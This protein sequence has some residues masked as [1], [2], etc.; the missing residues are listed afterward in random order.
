MQIVGAL[1][2]AF[3]FLGPAFGSD[4][5]LVV[6]N[7]QTNSPG[8][9]TDNIGAVGGVDFHFQEVVDNTEFPAGGKILI[10][11][12][13][14]RAAPGTGPITLT[15]M[16]ILSLSTT[17]F[18]ANAIG[19]NTMLTNTYATNIGPDNTVV[20]SGPVTFTS[21]GCAGP[22]VC[23]FDMVLKFATP[24]PYDPSQGSLLLDFEH[25]GGFT[26]GGFWDAVKYSPPGGPVAAVSNSGD[27]ATGNVIPFGEVFQLS[28]TPTIPPSTT[29]PT[30]TASVGVLYSSQVAGTGVQRRLYLGSV[31][32]FACSAHFERERTGIRNPHGRR[33]IELHAEHHRQC[34]GER[35][36][37]VHHNGVASGYNLRM[38]GEYSI[39]RRR[40]LVS[41][42]LA[43]GGSGSGIWS[44][45]AGSL[46]PLTLSTGGLISGIPTAA[47]VL[48]F[49]VKIADSSGG[50]AQQPCTLTVT[51]PL[52]TTCPIA[53]ATI[54][55]VYF[56]PLIG[57]GGSGAGYSWSLA[58]GSLAPLTLDPS[59]VVSGSANTAVVLNFTLKI[60][61]SAGSTAQQPCTIVFTSLGP[62]SPKY[63]KT[64]INV[65]YSSQL[66]GFGGS[67]MRR[68]NGRWQVLLAWAAE[69]ERRAGWSLFRWPTATGTLIFNLLITDSAG[70]DEHY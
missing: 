26:G 6:P 24:F 19:G 3:V 16:T 5:L 59:G 66:V 46:A 64:A 7:A 63:S 17:P 38:S 32:R 13:A 52:S 36:T 25:I 20:F 61:D 12:V 70:G 10:T 56:S 57:T 39:G 43:I 65:A 37:T 60:T 18:A 48:T 47:G 8:N 49:T 68:S 15:T 2:T 42:S 23:P 55:S 4:A 9:V 58:G 27:I 1:L 28:F 41:T 50:S 62:T 35:S 44:L 22:G 11:Q 30:T 67:G 31:E 45:T 54:G 33:R 51:V 69:F 40:V 29:C 14:L 34:W 53:S 21:P